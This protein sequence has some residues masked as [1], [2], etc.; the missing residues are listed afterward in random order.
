M[1]DR[2]GMRGGAVKILRRLLCAIGLH[3]WKYTHPFDAVACI[4]G[5]PYLKTCIH[6][7]RTKVFEAV[8]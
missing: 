4:G 8:K 6:C 2:L 5:R 7:K 1:S 3:R